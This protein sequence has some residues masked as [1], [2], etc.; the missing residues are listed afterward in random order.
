MIQ[1]ARGAIQC[2]EDSRT[3]IARQTHKLVTS[4]I[5]ENN[6]S[7]EDI[8]SIQFTQTTDLVEL[9]CAAG[10]RRYGFSDVPLF[11]AQ[12]PETRGS[13]PR[14]IRVLL[15]CIR[16]SGEACRHM[17]LGGAEKLRPDI[18]S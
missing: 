14:V 11:C 12:E 2:G 16:D 9:N 6:I 13:M 10:L 4:I 7:L 1:A 3:E 18:V 15:T 5:E 17:Y 8:V